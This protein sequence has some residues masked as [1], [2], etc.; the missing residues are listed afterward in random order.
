MTKKVKGKVE[1]P[2]SYIRVSKM[3]FKLETSDSQIKYKVIAYAPSLGVSGWCIDE[4]IEVA[5]TV[6]TKNLKDQL[7]GLIGIDSVDLAIKI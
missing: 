4:A 5:D 1:K 2:I 6:A 3:I 7:E